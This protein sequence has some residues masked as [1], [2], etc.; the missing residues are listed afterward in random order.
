MFEHP[1]ANSVAM[2]F[3][4]AAQFGLTPNEIWEELLTMPDRL[5][6]DVKARYLDELSGGLARRLLEKERGD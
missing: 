1:G 5:P 2:L 3:E 6:E 4:S